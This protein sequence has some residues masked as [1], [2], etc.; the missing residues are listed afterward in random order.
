MSHIVHCLNKLDAGTQEKI[1]LMS[2]D[3]QSVLVVSYAELKQC[4][5]QSFHELSSS[6][7][8]TPKSTLPL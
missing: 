3:E 2:R 7:S 6:A 4:L 8:L 5:D 1:C